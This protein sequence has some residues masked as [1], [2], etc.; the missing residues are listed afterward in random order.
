[1]PHDLLESAGEEHNDKDERHHAKE[2]RG[3]IA[4]GVIAKV[5]QS[6]HYKEN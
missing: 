1:M 4:I 2:T 6:T 5:G 3:R